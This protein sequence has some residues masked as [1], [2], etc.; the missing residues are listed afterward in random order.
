MGSHGISDCRMRIAEFTADI[1]HGA[2]NFPGA[3]LYY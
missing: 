3:G 1:V 2:I